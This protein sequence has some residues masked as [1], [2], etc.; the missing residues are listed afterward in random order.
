[1]IVKY[2]YCNRLDRKI[3]FTVAFDLEYLK[4][5][6]SHTRNRE[7]SLHF[8]DAGLKLYEYELYDV[9]FINLEEEKK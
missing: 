8:S 1:M 7:I 4:K 6:D 3:I 2:R 9:D 5:I